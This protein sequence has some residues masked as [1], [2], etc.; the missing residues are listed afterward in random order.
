MVQVRLHAYKSFRHYGGREITTYNHICNA[1][2]VAPQSDGTM[3]VKLT[4]TCAGFKAGH[5]I[6]VNKIDFDVK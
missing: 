1:V 3:L 6:A 2:F 4:E 5:L